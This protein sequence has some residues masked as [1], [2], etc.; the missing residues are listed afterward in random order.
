MSKNVFSRAPCRLSFGGGG[1]ELSPYVDTRGGVVLNATIAIYAYC[2]LN[3]LNENSVIFESSDMRLKEKYSVDEIMNMEA[4]ASNLPL[5]LGVYQYICKEYLN[6]ETCPISLITHTDAPV[7]SGLGASSTMTV[8][9][10]KA[11]D[12]YLS[13]GL[14]EY[15]LA[16]I[17][18]YVERVYLNL[19]G[20]RQDQY[21]AAFGGFNYM[22]FFADDKVIINPL[23]VKKDYINNLELNLLLYYS[24][25]SRESANIIENQTMLLESGDKSIYKELDFI[26]SL[27]P[28]MKNSILTNSIIDFAELLNESWE[29][30]KNTS[31]SITTREIDNIYST[32]I[33]NGALAGKVSGAGGGGFILFIVPISNRTK[34]IDAIEN[35]TDQ[36]VFF[37]CVF[38]EY[39]AES[40]SL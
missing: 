5:H 1:T 3:K 25:K 36:G 28:K 10:I 18:Y 19:N 35:S 12:E 2:N 34:V 16:K 14:G 6:N 27:A 7:G 26:K 13:L 40:W 37:P 24:G 23:R 11:F 32:A 33:E 21:A 29:H 39:G 8:A 17:A 9:I 20:G 30:K 22:E 31:S 4:K 38:T 15:E